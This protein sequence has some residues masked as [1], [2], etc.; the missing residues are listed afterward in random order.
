MRCFS[1]HD[2]EDALIL[3]RQRVSS[4]VDPRIA[5]PTNQHHSY[6]SDVALKLERTDKRLHAAAEEA[7]G[8]YSAALVAAASNR[9]PQ[10]PATTTDGTGAHTPESIAPTTP[11]ISISG[12]GSAPHQA[13]LNAP[14]ATALRNRLLQHADGSNAV[15]ASSDAEDNHSKTSEHP[16]VHHPSET[17]SKLAIQYTDYDAE[18]TSSSGPNL[19]SVRWPA[20]VSLAQFADYQLIPTLVYELSYPR[21]PRIRWLYVAE[22]TV[23]TFGTFALLYTVTEQMIMPLIPAPGSSQPFWRS[24]LDLALPFML[25]YLLLFYIM[26]G[27]FRLC[28]ALRW[29]R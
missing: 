6:L 2:H 19:V 12:S 26:F 14:S 1:D 21:T 9:P 22:K 13:F 16:L 17:V 10:T 24:L 4:S 20:N 11:G 25:A 23:A 8:S 3:R 5:T 7:S 15:S 29:R 27:E 28:E 18:L